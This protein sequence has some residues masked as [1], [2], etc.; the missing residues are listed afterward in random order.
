MPATAHVE[1]HFTG[2]ESVRDVVIGMADGLTVPFALA[3]GLSAAVTS[4]HIV[5]TAGLAE[6]VAGAISGISGSGESRLF[7]ISGTRARQCVLWVKSCCWSNQLSTAA[8]YASK[9]DV[10]NHQKSAINGRTFC[11]D[12]ERKCGPGSTVS[13]SV[14]FA[15]KTV[16]RSCAAFRTGAEAARRPLVV[17]HRAD[18]I[19]CVSL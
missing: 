12:E 15:L 1:R 3:A 7:N 13:Q 17:P 5:V 11:A 16:R 14:R 2:S 4:T 6:I 10:R 9:T 18:A 19:S 8:H